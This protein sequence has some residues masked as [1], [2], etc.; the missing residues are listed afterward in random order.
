MRK[1]AGVKTIIFTMV[2]GLIVAFASPSV[3]EARKVKRMVIKEG[4]EI[5]GKIMRPEM[6]LVLQRSKINYDAL[7][8]KESFL[9]RIVRSVK[10]EPF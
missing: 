5:R 8:L 4:I 2:L 3:V 9:P 6:S 7:K 10:Q 1:R